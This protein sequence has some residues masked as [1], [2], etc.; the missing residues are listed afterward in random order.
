MGLLLGLGGMPGPYIKYFVETIGP[1]GLHRMLAGTDD[2]RAEARCSMALC[3]PDGEMRVF[4]GRCEG[5][6]VEPLGP[7]AF[8]FD[9]CFEPA[10]H[11]ETYAEMAAELKNS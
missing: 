8:G 6:I 1:S 10:G 4:V 11:S 7:K 3:R 5:R 9:P 2:K